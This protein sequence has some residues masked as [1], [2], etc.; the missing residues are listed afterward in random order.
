M[1]V[2]PDELI[3]D[4][5]DA[6]AAGILKALSPAVAEKDIHVTD[7]L[8]AL[9][10]IQLRH[11]AHQL[12]RARGNPAPATLDVATH[13]IFA[14]GTC[15]SKA[16]G[17]IERMSEDI[18]IKVVLDAI[19]PG[20]ALPHRQG[21]RK[22]LGD[23]HDAVERCLS[24]IGFEYA[25]ATSG[26]NPVS[27]DN[28]RYYCL[29]VSYDARFQDVSGA[30]RPQLKLELIHRPPRL[31]VE[32]LEMGYLLDSFIPREQ[33]HR[34]AMACLSAAETLAEKVLSMLRRCAWNWDGYQRGTFDTALI[35]H[36]HDV[37]C[38][39][40]SNPASLEAARTV[41]ADLVRQDAR[42]FRGQ[43]PRFDTDPFAVLRHT[44]ETARHREALRRDFDQRLSP[45]IYGDDRP[46]FDTCFAAF[47]SAAR[48]LLA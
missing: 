7:A 24:D 17:L 8:H 33:P 47:A 4:I 5:E 25:A 43:H 34:F 28:R 15:L 1:K 40:E 27:R 44:L 14:G 3:S 20:Y 19:P 21:D 37:R 38:I 32:T 11:V 35:R 9:S 39:V 41:F 23:L 29:A 45:L 16:H 31:P 22:R 48:E 10:R 12:N 2:I 26:D 42:E 13:L 6:A 46:T 36:I 30:L 18:D